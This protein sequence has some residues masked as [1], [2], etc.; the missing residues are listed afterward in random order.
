MPANTY[1]LKHH[2]VEVRYETDITP[3]LTALTYTDSSGQRGFGDGQI[4]SDDTGLGTLVSVALRESTDA[5]G[6]RFGFFLPAV[7]PPAG[8]AAGFRTAG[9]YWTFS[10]PDSVPQRAASYR[11][12]ELA[13]TAQDEIHPL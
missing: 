13:G 3:G 10:G 4:R 9:V 8:G 5:G 2:E 1:T 7:D 11:C 6:E 12:I